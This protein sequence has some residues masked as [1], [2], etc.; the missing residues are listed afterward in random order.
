M[1][2]I[3]NLRERSG[4]GMMD[5]KKALDE[6]GNDLEKALEL[7]RKKGIAKAAKREGRI[8]EEGIVELEINAAGNEGYI[9]EMN[10]ETDFVARNEKFQAFA[11]SVLEVIKKSQPADM[12][13]LLSLPM[14]NGTVKEDLDALSGTIGEKLSLK[15]FEIVKGATVAGYSHMGGKIGV[16]IA[17]DAPGKNDLATDLAMQVAASNPKYIDPKEVPA[18]DIEKEKE[19]ER[20]VLIKENKPAQMV[21]KILE[22]KINKFF[23]SVCL[24][25]QEYIKDDK[26][27]VEKILG[28]ASVL[29]FV[30]YS[31]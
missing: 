1:E 13:S 23:E 15:S 2:L 21:E 22:G 12:E 9:L 11:K 16:L 3:K 24:I 19:I 25:K 17:L 27:K 28:T 20:E 30:R 29:K 10:A 6:A 31:L 5:C 7:L 14:A 26:Q 8:A 4:A 18:A